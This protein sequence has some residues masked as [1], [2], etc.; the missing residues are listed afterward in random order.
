MKKKELSPVPAAFFLD[1]VVDLYIRVSTTEQA[2][3]GYSVGEQEARL[4]SYAA[5]MG[6]KINAVH[7][8]PG[9]SGATLDRPG[10][11][12][13][14]NDVRAGR[15]RRVIVWK[16]DRL[17]RSQKDTLILLE[18]VFLSNGCN[19]ISLIESFDTATPFGRCMVGILA[20]FAQMERENI[21]MRTMMGKQAGAKDG[22]YYGPCAPLG[23]VYER[24]ANGKRELKADPFWS[25]MVRDFFGALDSGSSLTSAAEIMEEKY[26]FHRDQAAVALGFI[27]RNPVYAGRVR[28]GSEEYEGKHEAI[29]APEVWQR[30]NKR[31]AENKRSY[32]HSTG[33]LCG[34]L[35]CGD[36]G[37]RMAVRPWNNKGRDKKYACY[38]VSRSNKRMIRSDN[39]SNRERLYTVEEL[40][41]LV[42]AEVKKLSLDRSVFDSLLQER[43]EESGP[44][45]CAFRERM[46]DIERQIKRLLTLYQSGVVELEEIQARL[47]DLK[48]ERVKVSES[49]E[50]LE[51]KNGPDLSPAAAWDKLCS[52]ET[53]INSGDSGA[54]SALIR[55][56]I[57]KVVVLNE[58]ITIYWAFC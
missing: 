31:L 39:C 6:Y 47:L 10:I 1:N 30:V 35:F 2:E 54:V 51:A 50:N 53:I 43:R 48:N 8:D 21:K 49:I 36:C 29:V 23:Y 3:E 56:L 15:C 44:D 46:D 14:I 5:A 13:V 32:E 37:A 34:L 38:S 55:T 58:D 12:R 52:L 11:K 9:Y 57:K 27:A 42:L 16:L 18:D 45:L 40:D 17:S 25:Q 41:G 28:W 26:G 7:I 4:R 20:A 19:F 24:G 22:N 33:L